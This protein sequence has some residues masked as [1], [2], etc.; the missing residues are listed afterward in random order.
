MAED[1]VPYSQTKEYKQ[2]YQRE[3]YLK[4]REAVLER[5]KA[6]READPEANRKKNREAMARFRARQR[7]INPPAPEP[8]PLERFNQSYELDEESGCWRWKKSI[9][10]KGYAVM[11]IHQVSVKM[12]RW[13]Y[14][15]FIG[16]IPTEETVDHVCHNDDVSCAGGTECLHRRCVNPAHLDLCSSVE[17]SRRGKSRRW[18]VDKGIK[19]SHCPRGHEF[20][21][22]NTVAYGPDGRYRICRTCNN[23]RSLVNY[24]N[25]R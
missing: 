1:N 6:Q 11:K 15:H 4:R 12:H 5:Q 2:A 17:N 19:P 8:T 7:E 10:A 24:Y 3:Y 23:A 22:D 25:K 18:H 13:S 20:T 21:P 9:D 14:E 16:P